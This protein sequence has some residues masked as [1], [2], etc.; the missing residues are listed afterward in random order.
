MDH[1]AKKRLN[2]MNQMAWEMP[3]LTASVAVET[4]KA[5]S[6]LSVDFGDLSF[7]RPTCQSM[8]EMRRNRELYLRA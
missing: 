1:L 6:P 7:R 4:L 2:G 8:G 5:V 3:P